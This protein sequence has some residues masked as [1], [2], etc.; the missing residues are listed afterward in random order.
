M[1][2]VNVVLAHEID[3]HERNLGDFPSWDEAEAEVARRCGSLPRPRPVPTNTDADTFTRVRRI[4][5]YVCGHDV[6][7]LTHVVG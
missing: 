4:S 3:P 6:Y 7:R 5:E 2:R 1:E